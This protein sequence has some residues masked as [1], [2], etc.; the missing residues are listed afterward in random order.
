MLVLPVGRCP[1]THLHIY[2]LK[3][4]DSVKPDAL[5][6]VRHRFQMRK[7]W[8]DPLTYSTK[9]SILSMLSY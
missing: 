2:T 4:L 9:F 3:A 7:P 5:T 8:A 6:G 1:L